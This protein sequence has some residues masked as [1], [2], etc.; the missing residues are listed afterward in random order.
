MATGESRIADGVNNILAKSLYKEVGNLTQ[1]LVFLIFQ[2]HKKSHIITQIKV[3][4]NDKKVKAELRMDNAN[5]QIKPWIKVTPHRLDAV[6][7]AET[8]FLPVF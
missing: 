8:N 1:D 6:I 7:E 2:L 4:K 5:F 3:N